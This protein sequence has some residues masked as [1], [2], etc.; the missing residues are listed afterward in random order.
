MNFIETLS[1]LSERN[2]MKTE[3]KYVYFEN[4]EQQ[5]NKLIYQNLLLKSH[6][7]LTHISTHERKMSVNMD[8]LAKFARNAISYGQIIFNDT[9]LY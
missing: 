1:T 4:Y 2:A 8:R 3:A 9:V 6:N 5:E 7:F